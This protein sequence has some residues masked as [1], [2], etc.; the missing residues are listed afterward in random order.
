MKIFKYKDYNEYVNTQIT[1]NVIKISNVYVD[2]ISLNHLMSYIVNTL[3]ITPKSILCHGTSRG[4]EQKIIKSKLEEFKIYPTIIGTE[5]SHTATQFENTIQWDFNLTK[6]EW[7]NNVDVI[8]SNS[9]DHCF[10]PAEC[11]DTWMSC[12]TQN[13]VCVLEYS[14][15]CDTN[16]SKSDPFGA[17]LDE[18]KTLILKKYEIV[19][20]ISNEN[21]KGDNGNAYKGLRYFIIIQHKK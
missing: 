17:T 18:Y 2:D 9:F 1:T 3:H 8:Y 15:I 21:L 7:K 6:E 4:L 16:S 12:V 19:D 5:I 14:P 20:I 10:D 11:L 13:G